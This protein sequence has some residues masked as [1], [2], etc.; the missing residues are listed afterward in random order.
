MSDEITFVQTST[1]IA[2]RPPES[3]ETVIGLF[4]HG[5]CENTRSAYDRDIRHFQSAV[6]QPLRAVGL[7]DVQRY[8]DLLGAKGLS[9]S[10]RHRKLSSVRSL[11]RFAHVIG[12]AQFDVGRPLRLPKFQDRLSERILSEADVQR[13]IALEE[14]ER[15]RSILIALYGIGC[16]VTELCRLSVRD[17]N[18]R[19]DGTGN[20]TLYG[21]GSKTNVVFAPAT[22][23]SIIEPLIVGLGRDDAVFRSRHGK[24]L[25]RETVTRIVA[26]AAR[27]ARIDKAV[28]AHWMRHAHA[29]HAIDRG[30][31]IS[32]VTAQLSH[33]SAAVTSRYVHARPGDS[34]SRYLSL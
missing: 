31:P 14:N 22:I 25:R 6:A 18:G 9:E 7:G 34:S 10:S 20:V 29:S 27:R 19:G 33:S 3:D 32:L 30:S 26:A 23:W 4:L 2:L 1:E 5:R 11:L 13:M 16:R 8:A 12:Y 24:R 17:C 21:K 28:S 15:N